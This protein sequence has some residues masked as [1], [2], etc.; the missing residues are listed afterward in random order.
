MAETTERLKEIEER[1][2]VWAEI[3]SD[4]EAA[5]T[6]SM[7]KA[8]ND[9]LSL[10]QASQERERKIAA[11]VSKESVRLHTLNGIIAGV[12]AALQPGKESG[13]S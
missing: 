7:L 12:R 3:A 1:A 10:L 11:L 9:L 4:D 5:P 13:N 6:G 2:K 8:I